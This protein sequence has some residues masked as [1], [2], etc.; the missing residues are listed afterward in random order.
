MENKRSKA[1]L[2]SIFVTVAVMIGMLGRFLISLYSGVYEE[3]AEMSAKTSIEMGL[4]PQSVED[5]ISGHLTLTVVIV[6]IQFI[7]M[8]FNIIGYLKNNNVFISLALV[9]T[10]IPLGGSTPI[11]FILIGL[12]IAAIVNVRAINKR[13]L[14]EAVRQQAFE[15][16][17]QQRFASE[18]ID[19]H[20]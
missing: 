6:F 19:N 3:L 8:I 14:I 17:R 12:L 16:A 15:E 11:S 4:E 20:S 2:I 10:I 7:G 18:I 5:I 9:F 1:A 13:R